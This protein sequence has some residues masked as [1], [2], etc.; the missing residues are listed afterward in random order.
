MNNY[1]YSCFYEELIP[2]PKRVCQHEDKIKDTEKNKHE[3]VLIFVQ[4]QYN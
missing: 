2:Y 1:F 3:K 4:N